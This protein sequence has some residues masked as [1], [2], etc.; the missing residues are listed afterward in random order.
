LS[1]VIDGFNTDNIYDLKGR[2]KANDNTFLE[3]ANELNLNL[4]RC[5]YIDDN[6]LALRTGKQHNMTTIMMINDIF[7]LEDY[8]IFSSYIDYK[9]NSFTELE[10]IVTKLF[11][12][13]HE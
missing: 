5:I 13:I 10:L 3:V 12:T 6:P 9:I 8:H 4:N 11:E 1:E 2:S 7:T